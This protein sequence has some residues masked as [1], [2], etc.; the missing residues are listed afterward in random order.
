MSAVEESQAGPRGHRVQDGP[1]GVLGITDRKRYACH[2]H[3]RAATRRHEI[4]RLPAGAVGVIGG[5]DVVAVM[6]GPAP[7]RRIDGRGRVRH[8]G[9]VVRLRS[10]ERPQGGPRLG[11]ERPESPVQKI[12]RLP[13]ELPPE[14]LLKFEHPPR[15]G[16][17]GTVIEILNLRVERPQ[18]GESA[19]RPLLPSRTAFLPL[20]HGEFLS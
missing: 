11:E 9:E 7:Q 13:L 19:S 4:E 14:L 15:A 5:D 12:D 16:A 1:D 18:R 3:S 2:D 10:D 17:E 6:Q 8:E 20:S